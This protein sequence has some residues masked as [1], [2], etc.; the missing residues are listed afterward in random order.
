MDA[1]YPTKWCN[2]KTIRSLKDIL[3]TLKGA[4]VGSMS[5]QSW[6]FAPRMTS[7]ALMSITSF[8][9]SHECISGCFS[10]YTG[11]IVT[12]NELV[13]CV[14]KVPMLINICV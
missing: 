6:L 12:S 2:I 5:F 8:D 14:E 7:T 10:S 11:I 3:D 13:C 9:Y 4:I 1:L